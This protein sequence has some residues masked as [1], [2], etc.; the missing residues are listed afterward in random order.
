[1]KKHANRPI[2]QNLLALG[3]PLFL[4]PD[5]ASSTQVNQTQAQCLWQAPFQGVAWV[6][7]LQEPKAKR[8]TSRISPCR[9][10][11]DMRTGHCIRT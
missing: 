11:T 7:G 4:A 8:S 9:R 2:K 5:V 10:E 3:F 1:M 6:W